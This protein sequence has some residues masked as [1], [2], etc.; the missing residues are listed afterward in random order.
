MNQN[1]NLSELAIDCGLL[2]G[3]A[4]KHLVEF[5]FHFGEEFFTQI[6]I[7]NRMSYLLD[8][9]ISNYKISKTKNRNKTFHKYIKHGIIKWQDEQDNRTNKLWFLDKDGTFLFVGILLKKEDDVF[10]ISVFYD[11]KKDFFF[12]TGWTDTEYPTLTHSAL[13]INE[14]M[15]W[16]FSPNQERISIQHPSDGFVNTRGTSLIGNMIVYVSNMLGYQP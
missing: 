10:T 9:D 6:N 5:S 14:E 12:K 16:R 11:N 15:F 4:P 3:K 2:M 7:C 1:P 8:L 13:E